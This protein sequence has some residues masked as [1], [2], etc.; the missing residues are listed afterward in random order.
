MEVREYVEQIQKNLE[1]KDPNQ[2][3][4]YRRWKNFT[5]RDSFS[6]RASRVC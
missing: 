5:Y 6:R 4:F 1:A 3:E 2:E